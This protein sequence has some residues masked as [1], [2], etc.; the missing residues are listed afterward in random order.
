MAEARNATC[1]A[2]GGKAP[3]RSLQGV[4]QPKNKIKNRAQKFF[5]WHNLNGA[6]YLAPPLPA[7]ANGSGSSRRLTFPTKIIIE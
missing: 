3:V 2:G 1:R 7:A 5:A 6:A 4:K